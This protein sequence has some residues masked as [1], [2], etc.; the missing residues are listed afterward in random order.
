MSSLYDMLFRPENKSHELLEL[1]GVTKSDIPRFRGCFWDGEFIVIETRTGGYNRM[2]FEDEATCKE[3]FP[4]LFDG[5]EKP[6]GPWNISIRNLKWFSH[7]RD[8]EF[9]CTYANFYFKVPDDVIERM[10]NI[11]VGENPEES[12]ETMRESFINQVK[13]T[14]DA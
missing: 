8:D 12:W 3:N 14:Q 6:K 5:D 4:E 1:L 7:D 11:S 10:K 13:G 2:F 9:D